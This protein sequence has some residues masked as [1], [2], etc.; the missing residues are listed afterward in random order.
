MPKTITHIEQ[1]SV[2]ECRHCAVWIHGNVDYVGYG[3]SRCVV[4]D[5]RHVCCNQPVFDEQDWFYMTHSDCVITVLNPQARAGRPLSDGY[6]SIPVVRPALYADAV[7]SGRATVGDELAMW[8][9]PCRLSIPPPTHRIRQRVR[10]STALWRPR[11]PT[12]WVDGS[13]SQTEGI[14]AAQV[15]V[16]RQRTDA[17]IRPR[18]RAST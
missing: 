1:N 6:R 4:S 5:E 15:G 3:L 8:R 10:T 18:S 17:A 14:T 12:C 11:P 7:Y 9:R 16:T 2:S 13:G